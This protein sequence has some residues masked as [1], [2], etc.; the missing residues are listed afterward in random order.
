MIS[1]LFPI[2]NADL[3]GLAEGLEM[4]THYYNTHVITWD[5]T[6]STMGITEL[7]VWIENF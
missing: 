5:V 7:T 3:L 4:N 2:V 6:L 1:S